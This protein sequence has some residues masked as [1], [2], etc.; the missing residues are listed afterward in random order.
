MN[1]EALFSYIAQRVPNILTVSYMDGDI[2]IFMHPKASMSNLA[3]LHNITGDFTFSYLDD[4]AVITLN[5]DTPETKKLYNLLT[6]E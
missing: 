4:C 3:A 5:Y 6:Y 2:V 1:T